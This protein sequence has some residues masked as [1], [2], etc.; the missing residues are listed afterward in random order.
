MEA[1]ATAADGVKTRLQENQQARRLLD[2]DVAAVDVRLA[3]FDDHKAAVKTNQEYTALLHE[4]STAKAEKEAIEDRILQLMEDADGLAAEL[5]AA[6]AELAQKK[7]D[8]DSER[9][10]LVKERG[11]L[12][13]EVQRLMDHR[14]RKM[15]DTTP[16]VFAKY[17]QILKSR[18]RSR[19]GPDA[20]GNLRRLP[21]APPPPGHTAHPP[22]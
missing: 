18:T 11:T 12:E 19:G 14:T 1:A 15:R 2:K 9:A 4:I 17:D 13:A 8:G 22:E 16:A 5:K 21:R 6:E 20:R 3:R 7:R 10:A